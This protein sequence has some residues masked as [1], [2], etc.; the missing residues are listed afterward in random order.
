MRPEAGEADNVGESGKPLELA[1]SL[2]CSIV[3]DEPLRKLVQDMTRLDLYFRT[4][5]LILGKM[6]DSG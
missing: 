2:N 5:L 6:R 1:K 3:S 4:F